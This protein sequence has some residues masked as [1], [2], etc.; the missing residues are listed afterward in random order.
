[1]YRKVISLSTRQ[2]EEKI[3]E[4]LEG[5]MAAL[6]SETMEGVEMGR[7]REFLRRVEGVDGAA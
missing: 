3:D 7:V 4:M 1:M 5:M 6:E 2:E